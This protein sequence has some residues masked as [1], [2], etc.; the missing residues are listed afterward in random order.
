MRGDRVTISLPNGQSTPG[1]VTS[2][3]TVAGSSGGSASTIPVDIRPL[4]P[5][6]AGT[7]DQASVE[8]QITNATV[9]DALIIPVSALLALGGGGYAVETVDAQGA[10]QL[11]AV[12]TGLFDDADGLVQA[13]GNLT[14]GE[15]VVVPAT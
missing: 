5:K 12:A 3:G 10:H 2:V 9:R 11:V 14:P 13:S 8:V 7:L 1:V 4:D 15:Q 6:V